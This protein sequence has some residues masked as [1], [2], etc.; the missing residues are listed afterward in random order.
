L[1][2][3]SDSLSSYF[4]AHNHSLR[5]SAGD[6]VLIPS[7]YVGWV[8]IIYA[9]PGAPSLSKENGKYLLVVPPSGILQTSSLLDVGY[10]SDEYFYVSSTGGRVRL[11]LEGIEPKDTDIIHSFRYQSGPVQIKT[12]FVGPRSL[13]HSYTEPD[14]VSSPTVPLSK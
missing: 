14:L 3:Q 5:I 8:Q 11:S 10:G 9:V 13:I 6:S 1:C 12:F 7:G 2:S 4:L